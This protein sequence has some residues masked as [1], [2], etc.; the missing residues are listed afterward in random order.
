M[1]SL[2][3]LIIKDKYNVSYKFCLGDNNITH[4]KEWYGHITEH[5]PMIYLT[6]RQGDMDI[7][8]CSLL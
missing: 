4:W 1:Y 3:S 2:N 7:L 6:L 8:V 5:P